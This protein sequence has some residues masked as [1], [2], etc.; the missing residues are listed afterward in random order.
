VIRRKYETSG[1][2]QVLLK[3]RMKS[4]GKKCRRCGVK[5]PWNH[6]YGICEGCYLGRY[7]DDDFW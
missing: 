4:M 2:I 3:E 7:Y 6:P 5:L 1:K